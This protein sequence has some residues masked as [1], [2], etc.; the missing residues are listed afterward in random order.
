MTMICK[1]KNK[2]ELEQRLNAG[3][4]IIEPTPW[5]NKYHDSKD[6]PVGFKEPVVLDPDTRRRFAEISKK[7]DGTWRVK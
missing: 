2:A 3:C 6:L 1:A 7:S 4:S 5:G